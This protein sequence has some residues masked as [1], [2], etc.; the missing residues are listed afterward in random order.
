MFRKNWNLAEKRPASDHLPARVQPIASVPVRIRMPVARIEFRV[1]RFTGRFTNT[2]GHLNSMISED[3]ESGPAVPRI[4]I[5]GPYDHT[6]DSGPDDGFGAGRRPA[7]GGARFQGH[8]NSGSR[9]VTATPDGIRDGIR[10][11][12][13]LAGP[14]VIST[15]NFLAIADNHSTDGRIGG[16]ESDTTLRFP[17]G[18]PHPLFILI[19]IR[20]VAHWIHRNIPFP[21]FGV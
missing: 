15:P 5:H 8:I 6:S 16:G 12:M 14:P 18:F 17:D 20:A 7:M 11:G 3:F 13:G 9:G 21:G 10:L 4:G 19:R 1:E 2:G